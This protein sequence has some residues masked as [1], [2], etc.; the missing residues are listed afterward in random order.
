MSHTILSIPFH[1]CPLCPHCGIICYHATRRLQTQHRVHPQ[2]TR[3]VLGAH[4]MPKELKNKK[5]DKKKPTMTPERKESGEAGQE[6]GP[7]RGI[8][9][10]IFMLSLHS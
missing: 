2:N 1:S 5:E 3:Q 8:C 6:R 7:T 10:S 4:T 9:L